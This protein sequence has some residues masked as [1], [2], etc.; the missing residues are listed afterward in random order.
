M[1]RR[2]V[3]KSKVSA[4]SV[5]L[6]VACLKACGVSREGF[7][8][9][10]NLMGDEA[11][12]FRR[13]QFARPEKPPRVAES[14]KLQGEAQ[15]IAIAPTPVNRREIGASQG[16]VPDQRVQLSRQGEQLIEL[17]GR[18]RTASRH[19]RIVQNND[20]EAH[21]RQHRR[22]EKGAAAPRASNDNREIM[23]FP[24]SIGTIE[25]D[26][27]ESQEFKALQQ[28]AEKLDRII[29]MLDHLGNPAANPASSLIA[30]SAKHA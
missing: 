10:V 29:R 25:N 6:F 7:R 11:K 26:T 19:G 8:R 5:E 27:R 18:Q 21:L 17:C 23:P 2:E 30:A 1:R 22:R 4:Q 3:G 16:P 9:S 24:E 13:D 14:A 20:Q 15:P 12:C 28:I